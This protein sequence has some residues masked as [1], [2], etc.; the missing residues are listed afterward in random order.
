MTCGSISSQVF[1]LDSWFP[2][3]Y[4]LFRRVSERSAGVSD[5]GGRQQHLQEQVRA[6]Q[7]PLFTERSRTLALLSAGRGRQER[8]VLQHEFLKYHSRHRSMGPVTA[9]LEKQ[10]SALHGGRLYGNSECGC[11]S[12]RTTVGV[13][14]PVLDACQQHL[15]EQQVR[16][17]QPVLEGVA[18]GSV[19][20]HRF[21]E[22]SRT[23]ALLSAR[24]QEVLNG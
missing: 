11:F 9:L 12:Q 14:E 7:P 15:Q 24:R 22:G 3:F 21:T 17:P 10:E 1:A 5:R 4:A 16:A 13:H 6:P 18:V 23:L 2:N 19:G 20:A 8:L